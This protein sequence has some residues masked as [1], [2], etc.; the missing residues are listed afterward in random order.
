MELAGCCPQQDKSSLPYKSEWS[1]TWEAAHTGKMLVAWMISTESVLGDR[2]TRET[3]G[4]S[5]MAL[6]RG[7]PRG[8]TSSESS[9]PVHRKV[10]LHH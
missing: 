4:L 3:R 10:H 6:T 2:A 7:H 8:G 5:L 9:A 1:R